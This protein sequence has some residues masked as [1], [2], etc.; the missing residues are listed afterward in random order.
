MVERVSG[1][2]ATSD[3]VKLLDAATSTGVGPT[4]DFSAGRKVIEGR[5]TGTGAVSAT[6]DIYRTM[7]AD[8]NTPAESKRVATITLSGTG[9]AR[10]G[11]VCDAP[12]PYWF[13]NLTAIS[14]T[15]AAATCEVSA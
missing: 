14:G 15:S 13:A 9:E 4:T 3:A 6:M 11:F 7:S 12:W 10:D 8:D 5:V 2:P 1:H